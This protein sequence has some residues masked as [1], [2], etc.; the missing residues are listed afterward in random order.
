MNSKERIGMTLAVTMIGTTALTAC[1][2]TV[3]CDTSS[4]RPHLAETNENWEVYANRIDPNG[5][6]PDHHALAKEIARENGVTLSTDKQ[7][8]VEAGAEVLLPRP[9]SCSV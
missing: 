5:L 9:N 2:D 3:T 1:G 7:L 6:I 4:A 8:T